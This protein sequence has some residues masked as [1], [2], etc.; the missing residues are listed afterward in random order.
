M[1]NAAIQL[2][3]LMEDLAVDLGVDA[4]IQLV[5]G[6]IRGEAILFVNHILQS[7]VHIRENAHRHI[8]QD[9]TAQTTGLICLDAAD[10]DSQNISHDLADRTAVAAAARNKDFFHRGMPC[11]F[12]GLQP[13][14]QGETDALD[15]GTVEMG[16]GVH[17]VQAQENAAGVSGN[18]IRGQGGLH[19]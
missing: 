19:D 14:V 9:G 18:G 3:Q 6:R 2:F 11:F 8:R 4:V 16:T 7:G 17:I 5:G 15:N 10:G 12:Q 1:V 13:L